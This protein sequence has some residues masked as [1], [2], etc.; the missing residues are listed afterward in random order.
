LKSNCNCNV[1]LY[2]NC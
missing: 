1:L 2:F